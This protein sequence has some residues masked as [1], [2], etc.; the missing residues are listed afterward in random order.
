[1][2]LILSLKCSLGLLLSK[3]WILVK[4]VKLFN[5]GK[6]V[7]FLIMNYVSVVKVRSSF[8]TVERYE[9]SDLYTGYLIS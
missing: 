7:S 9:E 8:W 6:Y 3:I 5:S 4:Q 1:M 2:K